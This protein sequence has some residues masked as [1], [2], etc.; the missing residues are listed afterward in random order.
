MHG[1]QPDVGRAMDRLG[2]T[3]TAGTD[4]VIHQGRLHWP[5][6]ADGTAPAP[7]PRVAGASPIE[8]LPQYRRPAHCLP[9]SAVQLGLHAAPDPADRGRRPADR[10][11]RAAA[12]PG[13]DQLHRR[14][15]PAVADGRAAAA[16]HLVDLRR[17]PGAV[18]LYASSAPG[19]CAMRRTS[20]NRCSC[21]SASSL[22]GDPQEPRAV[23]PTG[24]PGCS[25]SAS[26]TASCTRCAWRSGT[27][28]P[29]SCRAPATRHRSSAA[30]PIP[31]T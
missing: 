9:L 20:W 10:R 5:G 1:T 11:D 25:R 29:R 27:C 19:R 16:R 18:R 4:V 30:W 6:R 14:A 21:W 13:V 22:A 23:L 8:T 2:S 17:R 3:R 7:E 12:L 26:S 15:R 28:R 24:C 31:R